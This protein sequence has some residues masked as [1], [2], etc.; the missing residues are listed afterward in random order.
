MMNAHRCNLQNFSD[1]AA[2]RWSGHF[3]NASRTLWIKAATEI[4]TGT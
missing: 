2:A 1:Q 4:T 3:C